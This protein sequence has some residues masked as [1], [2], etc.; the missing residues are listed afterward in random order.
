MPT[1]DRRDNNRVIPITFNGQER[2]LED[3]IQGYVSLSMVSNGEYEF[4]LNGRKYKKAAPFFLC[5]SEKDKL[6]VLNVE[7]YESAQTFSF[8]PLF[9]N[10]SLTNE[11][12]SKDAFS[13]I[14]DMHDRNLINMFRFHDN[15]FSGIVD[16]DAHSF[17]QIREWFSIIGGETSMQS[18]GMWT[19][20]IR[21]Y[22]LQI[23]YLLEDVYVENLRNP[24][25]EKGIAHKAMEYI[26]TNYNKYIGMQDICDY[27]G[28]N[29]TTLN[30]KFK[31]EFSCTAMQY[32]SRYRIK[33]AQTALV[34]TNLTIEEIAVCCGYQYESYFVK[35]Y[36]KKTGESPSE[37]RKR[38]W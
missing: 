37:Y 11:A 36:Q 7:N 33:M 2:F 26:H 34:H 12:L 38:K 5:L 25:K 23:L 24:D 14:E 10:S 27:I 3:P 6:E 20:R 16:I 4:L 32:L 22:L 21:R 8:S 28:T 17:L 15:G 19:C 18:D 1:L 35:A 13:K 29:R 9:L 30:Q 31:E